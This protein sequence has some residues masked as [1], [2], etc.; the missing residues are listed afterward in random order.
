MDSSRAAAKAVLRKLL[1]RISANLMNA[2]AAKIAPQRVATDTNVAFAVAL[3][4][5][6]NPP[7]PALSRHS[8]AIAP[9]PA[10]SVKLV[11]DAFPVLHVVT[12]S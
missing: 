1:R 9:R 3:V 5:V 12:P 10:S 11:S 6:N 4:G 8:A 7:P 2:I